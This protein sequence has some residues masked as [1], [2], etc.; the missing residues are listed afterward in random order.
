ME[1]E[2]TK[3]PSFGLNIMKDGES[4]IF[5]A[6][7]DNATLWRHVGALAIYNHAYIDLGDDTCTRIWRHHDSYPQV[8]DFMLKHGFTSHDN[9]RERDL[10]KHDVK[11]Y[12]DMIAREAGDFESL[13]EGWE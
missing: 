6:N 10:N 13:P 1:S 8:E 12:D 2:A 3:Q 7:P 11:A 4:T 5:E 9:L